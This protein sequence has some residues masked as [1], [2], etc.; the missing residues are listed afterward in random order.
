[1]QTNK[2]AGGPGPP[3]GVGRRKGAEYD[4]SLEE[5]ETGE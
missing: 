2:E 3:G 5:D 4:D 1:M